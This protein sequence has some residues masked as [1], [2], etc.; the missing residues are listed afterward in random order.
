MQASGAQPSNRETWGAVFI[1]D[2]VLPSR[3]VLNG[4]HRSEGEAVATP[5]LACAGVP[6][7]IRWR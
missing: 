2:A 5:G 3:G 4:G 7:R 1:V 6:V